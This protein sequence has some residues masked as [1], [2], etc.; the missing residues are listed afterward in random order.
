LDIFIPVS[1]ERN[2]LI[3]IDR[4]SAFSGA[5]YGYFQKVDSETVFTPGRSCNHPINKTIFY[6]EPDMSR[7]GK[8]CLSAFV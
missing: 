2:A 3:H 1:A 5:T 8:A 7:P 4:L 6:N